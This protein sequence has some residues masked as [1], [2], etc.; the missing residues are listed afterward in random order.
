VW[1]DAA[2]F[3]PELRSGVLSSETMAKA[4]HC[5]RQAESGDRGGSPLA[6]EVD[7]DPEYQDW[8]REVPQRARELAVAARPLR[9]PIAPRFSPRTWGVPHSL[10]AAFALVAV[11]LSLW[12]GALQRRVETLSGPIF[13]APSG[14]I[15]LGEVV[16][17][18]STLLVPRKASHVTLV[19]TVDSSIDFQ[20]GYLEIVS[21][22]GEP[23]WRSERV[24]LTPGDERHLTLPRQR[25]P[26]G[27]Y[28]VRVFPDAGFGAPPLA[29]EWLRVEGSD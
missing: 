25:L 7:A 13:D 23:V 11:G 27:D 14:E 18:E 17:G 19:F 26:Y 4:L 20:D 28:R 6:R 24:R 5:S 12:V 29:E 9:A 21:R 8:I 22:S 16:R 10:A 15:A 2:L 3:E 1:L